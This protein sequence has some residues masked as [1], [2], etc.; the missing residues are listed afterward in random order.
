MTDTIQDQQLQDVREPA[1]SASNG[2]P[3]P[4]RSRLPLVLAVG[5]AAAV[6]AV[7][8]IA[9]WPESSSTPA[10]AA[11]GFASGTTV[12]M[13]LSCGGPAAPCSGGVTAPDGTQWIWSTTV[14]QK[15]P[16]TWE[17]HEVTGS[18]VTDGDWGT[19]SYSAGAR[20]SPCTGAWRPPSTPTSADAGWASADAGWGFG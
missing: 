16:T 9:F 6:L 18:L 3:T 8:A 14:D 10:A 15:I 2:T 5:G 12:D 19:V 4:S 1:P 17:S 20:P 11:P 13:V 7:A